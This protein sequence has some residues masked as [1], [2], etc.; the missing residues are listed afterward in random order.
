MISTASSGNLLVE[1]DHSDYQPGSR[2]RGRFARA[3]AAIENL[4]TAR[5]CSM[6]SAER[7][8]PSS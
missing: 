4:K 6:P 8:T 1:I 2:S 5:A 3:E 7:R